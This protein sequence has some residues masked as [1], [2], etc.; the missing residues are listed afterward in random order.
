MAELDEY[1]EIVR[2][3]AGILIG[4]RALPSSLVTTSYDPKKHAIKGMLMP[5][6]VETGWVPI[7]V[8]GAGKNFGIFIGPHAG[9]PQKLDGDQFSIEFE[10]GDP[11]TPVAR[12]RLS[13]DQDTPVET[14]SGEHNHIS[15]FNHV[16]HAA[17]KDGSLSIGTN[18]KDV[19][20][21]NQNSNPTL[22]HSAKSSKSGKSVTHTHQMDPVKGT[23]TRSSANGD[24]THSSIFDLA[25]GTLTHLTQKGSGSHSVVLDAVK[26]IITQTSASH[27]RQ[28]SQGITDKAASISHDGP[29]SVAGTLGVSGLLSGTGGAKFGFASFEIDLEGFFDATSGGMVTGGLMVDVLTVNAGAN[30]I[31]GL[32]AD[33]VTVTDVL[34]LPVYSIADLATLTATVGAMVYLSDTTAS[35]APTFNA[36]PIGGGSTTVNRPVTFDGSAWRY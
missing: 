3:E 34:Q 5:H 4:Q 27:S 18:D 17:L 24:T 9:D 6:G 10:N 13:S 29:T 7:G 1:L 14:Q 28:A 25:A 21:Q 35:A 8:Q 23:F 36:I 32:T 16:I 20:G 19:A 30:V 31:G 11:N 15:Q 22:S 12:H 26:G 2:R 33:V